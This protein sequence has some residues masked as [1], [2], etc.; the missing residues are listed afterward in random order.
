MNLKTVAKA[1]GVSTATVSNVI[2]GVH[3]KVSQQTIDRVNKVIRELNY[4]PSAAARS[5]ASKESRIIGL[6]IPNTGSGMS[7][8]AD[9][10]ISDAIAQMERIVRAEGYYL[11]LRAVERSKEI[12]NLAQIWAI[13][14][15][16]ILG[17]FQDDVTEIERVLGSIPTVYTDTYNAPVPIANVGIDDYKGG[18]LS[19]RCFLGKGHKKIALVTPEIGSH[20]VLLERYRGFTDALS[21]RGITLTREDIFTVNSNRLEDGRSAGTKIAMSGR[22]YTA[23]AAS[24][25]I[26]GLG[27]I[28]GLQNAGLNVPED[29]SVTGFDNLMA[30]R[31]AN[32][33]MTTI[34]QDLEEKFSLVGKHLFK[35][36]QSKEKYAVD[37]RIDVE[38]IERQTVKKL[39]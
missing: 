31:Y 20:G 39:L 36:I 23:V 30:S 26:L 18:F 12:T 10:Y 28:K 32:P 35:M 17:A 29:V 16:V 13:D 2:N 21:E 19:A 8:S 22:G 34:S 3:G 15:M 7:F 25:D 1:A 37:E 24:S 5:L 38:L 33:A 11:M 14:G 27:V 9:P 4:N 6:V